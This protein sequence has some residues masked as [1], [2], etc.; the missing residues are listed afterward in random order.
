M[1]VPL[2]IATREFHG[3]HPEIGEV[4]NAR[5]TQRIDLLFGI[6][7]DQDRALCF[8]AN[9]LREGQIF[10]IGTAQHD[11]IGGF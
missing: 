2:A 5:G 9:F 3:V 7:G 1:R 4:F 11:Q 6:S 8:A 10:G